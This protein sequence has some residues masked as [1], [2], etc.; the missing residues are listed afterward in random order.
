MDSA[1]RGPAQ[2]RQTVTDATGTATATL[3]SSE[4]GQSIVETKVL[5]K[6]GAA[7]LCL[8]RHQAV[9]PDRQR[10]LHARLYGLNSNGNLI[11][12]TPVSNPVNTPHTFTVQVSGVKWVWTSTDSTSARRVSLRDDQVLVIS[13]DS[14]FNAA[15]YHHQRRRHP[16]PAG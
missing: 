13:R 2:E 5:D 7:G 12:G 10:G 1:R 3:Y 15:G 4:P 9:V 11:V 14:A 16:R 8:H 6:S